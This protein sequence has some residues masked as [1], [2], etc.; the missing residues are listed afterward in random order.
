MHAINLNKLHVRN[1]LCHQKLS[2][3]TSEETLT[4]SKHN[5]NANKT[6]ERR[7]AERNLHILTKQ[8]FNKNNAKPPCLS[9]IGWLD[10]LQGGWVEVASKT[11]WA[12]HPET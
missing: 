2:N 11:D 5:I 6:N 10:R 3:K 7:D 12:G 8:T 4:L 1:H 9:V